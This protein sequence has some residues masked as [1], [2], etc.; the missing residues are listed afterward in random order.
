MQV[1]AQL[2]QAE[3]AQSRGGWVRFLGRPRGWKAA[4]VAVALMA[5]I[6]LGDALSRRWLAYRA[7]APGI[8]RADEID[9][10]DRRLLRALAA[11]L[12]A[13]GRPQDARR[14]NRLAAAA[15]AG[16]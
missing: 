11:T 14:L 12:Q 8:A 3:I 15:P 10:A 7:P 13:Q 5:G 2:A 1:A 9:D 6:F 16:N 4:A